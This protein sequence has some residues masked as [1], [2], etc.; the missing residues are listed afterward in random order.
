MKPSQVRW[1]WEL[2]T[3]GRMKIRAGPQPRLLRRDFPRQALPLV[4]L[5]PLPPPQSSCPSPSAGETEEA[6]VPHSGCRLGTGPLPP[7]QRRAPGGS[8]QTRRLSFAANTWRRLDL[9]LTSRLFYVSIRF[10]KVVS[11]FYDL[12]GGLL[13]RACEGPRQE[14][15][16]WVPAQ[17]RPRF[18]A[19]TPSA[20]FPSPPQNLFSIAAAFTSY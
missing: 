2:S 20:V 11:W 7:V 19:F 9:F 16:R 17:T 8:L 12:H 13:R 5:P 15:Q 10:P 14:R 4:A 3:S 6:Q 18:P 1:L